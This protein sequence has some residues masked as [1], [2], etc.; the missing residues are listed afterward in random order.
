MEVILHLF[1]DSAFT[2]FL[3]VIIGSL[4]VYRFSIRL[5]RRQNF[6]VIAEKFRAAL[7][8]EI[9]AL[10]YTSEDPAEILSRSFTK[11]ET[12]VSELKLVLG[13]CDKKG[14]EKAW[15]AY[16]PY[17]QHPGNHELPSMSQYYGLQSPDI[18][19]EAVRNVAIE[20]IENLLKFAK[21][22]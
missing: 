17:V 19:P 12:A 1:R 11:H 6:N 20:R 5:A 2:G 7:S 3:G 4:L 22:K 10:R 21:P 8:D 16:N 15:K 9:K 14:L 18:E 13:R